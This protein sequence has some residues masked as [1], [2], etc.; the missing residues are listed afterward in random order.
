[1]HIYKY[2]AFRSFTMAELSK[3][4]LETHIHKTAK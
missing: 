4:T 3:V 2:E 1:M